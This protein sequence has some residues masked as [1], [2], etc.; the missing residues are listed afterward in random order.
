M[1]EYLPKRYDKTPTTDE[2][3]C[4]A[5]LGLHLRRVSPTAVFAIV[6]YFYQ[7]DQTA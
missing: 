1:R 7:A 4:K 5:P 2:N 3:S 6:N